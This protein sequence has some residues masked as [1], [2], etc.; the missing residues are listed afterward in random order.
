M[1]PVVWGKMP[2]LF[3]EN[4]R[5]GLA[6]PVDALFHIPHQKEV[7]L[8]PGNRPEEHV[9]GFIGILVLVHKHLFKPL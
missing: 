6:E 2:L 7:F 9:L 4:L 5:H 1:L 8:L 3:Q